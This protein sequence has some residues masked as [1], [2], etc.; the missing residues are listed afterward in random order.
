MKARVLLFVVLASAASSAAQKAEHPSFPAG[1]EIVTVDLVVLDRQGGPIRGLTR[2][3]FSVQEDG[4]AQEITAFEAVDHPVEPTS[5]AATS[6]PLR[7]ATSSNVDAES[8]T[9]RG[10]VLVFDELHLAPSEAKSAREVVRHFLETGVTQGDHVTLVGTAG[11]TWWTARIP[12]G[13]DALLQVAARLQG[14][15]VQDF[16]RDEMT[17]YEAMRIDR[18]RDPIVTDRVARRLVAQGAIYTVNPARGEPNKLDDDLETRRDHARG[19]AAEVYARSSGQNATILADMERALASLTTV[20]GRKSLILVSGGLVYDM[21]LAG[22]R[23]VVDESRRANV[24]IYFLDARGL[25]ASPRGLQADVGQPMDF[26]D[27]GSMLTEA[28]EA[29]DGAVSLAADTGGFSVENQNDLGSGISRIARESASYYLLGYSPTNK[30]PDGRFRKIEVKVRGSGR[31]VRARRGYYAQGNEAGTDG[32]PPEP[33]DAAIQRAID[34]PFDL[35]DVPLRAAVHV[36]DTD[37]KGKARVVL[38]VEADIR[39]LAFSDNGGASKDTLEMM[40]VVADRGTG[41]F[42]RFDQQ[43]NMNFRPET[44]ARYAE[45]WFPISRE[46]PL[47]AG[48]FQA[49]IVAR[50]KNSGRVGSL[51]HDFDVPTSSGFR[52]STPVLSDRLRETA[53]GGVRDPEPTARRVFA[54]AGLLH[55]R[56]EIYGAAKDTGT[57]APRVTAG[58]S[59]RRSDGKFLAAAPE[60]PLT[61]AP[62]GTLSRTMG[63]SL[64]GAPVG[65]YEMIVVATDL[66]AGQAAEIRE[67]F[68]IAL[69]R[70]P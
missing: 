7:H 14:R 16:A 46:V 61:P 28:H 5:A 54:P 32:K 35:P 53:V 9:A 24:V 36:L 68:E 45:T 22:F 49:R 19:R 42:L 60:T 17:D 11:T 21:H 58:F 34:S 63:A 8:R 12:E 67:P 25:T 3:D 41:D 39:P 13:R 48:S 51:T 57:G 64:D 69:D 10:F 4:V 44:R 59:I 52:I 26:N 56:F 29:T 70:G 43:F 50:D 1:T 15:R 55:C 65:G 2:E 62:D 18:D 6:A 37:E 30:R 47:G 20:R 27:L 38:T 66:V 31:S 23:R 40:L 33:R